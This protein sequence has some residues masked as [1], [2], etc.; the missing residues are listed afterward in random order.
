V[1]CSSSHEATS[2]SYTSGELSA[3]DLGVSLGYETTRGMREV[4]LP[5]TDMDEITLL[6]ERHPHSKPCTNCTCHEAKS[7]Q[8]E[9]RTDL[10]TPKGK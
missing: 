4:V 7:L 8:P 1:K 2:S 9:D 10:K 5:P 6:S 3:I